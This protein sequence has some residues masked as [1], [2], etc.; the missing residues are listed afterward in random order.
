[1]RFAIALVLFA[2]VTAAHAQRMHP[3]DICDYIGGQ[4]DSFA[5]CDDLRGVRL[6]PRVE[7][8]GHPYPH[9]S[10]GHIVHI[11]APFT[12][13]PEFRVPVNMIR[14]CVDRNAAPE[15]AAYHRHV[16]AARHAEQQR[17]AAY[18][19]AQAPID[20]TGGQRIQLNEYVDGLGYRIRARTRDPSSCPEVRP[21]TESASRPL[22]GPSSS[23]SSLRVAP[24]LISAAPTAPVARDG[25]G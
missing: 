16:E 21:S 23:P 18:E 9:G 17:I 19:A 7:I 2:S 11:R 12:E 4:Y 10:C 8:S 25:S 15:T 1:M 20:A 3:G 24:S 22:P 14:N 5:N 6:G 13:R